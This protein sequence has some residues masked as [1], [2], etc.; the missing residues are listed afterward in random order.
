VEREAERNDQ[1]EA[2]DHETSCS[3]FQ[4]VFFRRAKVQ[5]RRGRGNALLVAFGGVGGVDPL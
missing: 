1:D 5:R 2:T 3:Q 4:P